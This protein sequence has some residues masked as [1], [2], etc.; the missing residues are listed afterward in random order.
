MF[1]VTKMDGASGAFGASGTFGAFVDQ[2]DLTRP[3]DTADTRRLV[4]SLYQ[5]HILVVRGQSGLSSADYLR[6]GQ[7]WGEPIKFYRPHH[8]DQGF[9]ELI[10]I[11]NSPDTPEPQ[12][13]GAMHWHADSSYEPVPASVTMLLAIEAP[14]VGNETLFADMAAAWDALPEAMKARIENLQVRH[15]TSGRKMQ[16]TML[17]GEKRGYDAAGPDMPEVIQPLVLAHPATGR[18][19]LYAI[20]GSTIGIVGMEDGEAIA[21][22]KEL[23]QFALQQRFIQ[24]ARA[25]PGSIVIWD[26]FAVL[27]CATPTEYSKEDGKRRL[28]HRISTRGLPAVCG[29]PFHWPG[30]LAA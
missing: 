20:S 6:F 19:G 27:H 11:H 18:K 3:L 25:E 12:R 1:S 24:S 23:K 21:L 14:L 16:P 7:L 10:V 22:L 26:N 29:K 9:P 4:D 28:L 5:H 15:Q 17:A 8:R 13:D 2:I 30:R